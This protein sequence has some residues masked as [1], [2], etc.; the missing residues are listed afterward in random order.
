[1]RDE[2]KEELLRGKLFQQSALLKKLKLRKVAVFLDRYLGWLARTRWSRDIAIEAKKIV[3]VPF[4]G[5]YTCNLKYICEELIARGTDCDI[6][7]L[8]TKTP[9]PFPQCIRQVERGTVEAFRELLSA[10]VIVQN[11]Y[12][13]QELGYIPKQ[14][15]QYYVQT[16]HG[17]LG[18]KRFG[19]AEDSNKARVRAAKRS[20]K[21]DDIF[22]SNSTFET[23]EVAPVFWRSSCVYE[24]GHARNDI[25]IQQHEEKAA[26]IRDR[27][28]IQQDV[29]VALYA[30]TYRDDKNKEIYGLD[31]ERLV[32]SLER[33]F[34]GTWI[35]L[36]KYHYSNRGIAGNLKSSQTVLNVSQYADIQE[37][38]LIS[39]VGITDYSSWIFDY[40]LLCRP[41]FLYAED[42][43]SYEVERG[44]YYPLQTTPFPIAETNDA[45]EANIL[46]FDRQ[47]YQSG[48]AAFLK[49]KGCIEDGRAAKRAADWIEMTLEMH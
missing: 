27:L 44:F 14:Q 29:K 26:L 10:K 40:M 1:M 3:F 6:V 35:I 38:M 15:G 46:R 30:P 25:L 39:D 22:I 20:G 13:S 11:A 28:G 21:R 37:L 9:S 8:I 41:A 47:T 7:W 17:A 4:N 48:V 34:G 16:W 31:Y 45:L 5:Q 36:V 12:V 32:N 24:W 33:R 18:I 42:I 19:P 23:Q 49:E 2:K 43:A